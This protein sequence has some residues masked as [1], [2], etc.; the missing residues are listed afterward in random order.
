VQEFG[1][2]KFH[3]F[4]DTLEILDFPAIK[5]DRDCITMLIFLSLCRY[6]NEH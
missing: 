2:K 5:Y 6:A 1:A 4:A 3:G